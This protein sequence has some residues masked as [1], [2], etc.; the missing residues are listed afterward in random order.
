MGER[1]DDG[2]HG[3]RGLR[4]HARDKGGH[5]VEV[6][7]H[8][9]LPRAQGCVAPPELAVRVDGPNGPARCSA[10]H[11][12]RCGRRHRQHPSLER[13]APAGEHRSLGF[14]ARVPAGQPAR[15]LGDHV[16]M[17]R[18]D[19]T[20][21]QG[22]LRRGQ[23]TGRESRD[24]DPALRR[25]G[26]PTQRRGNLLPD[27]IRDPNGRSSWLVRSRTTYSS[28]TRPAEATATNASPGGHAV[29]RS[30]APARLH[31]R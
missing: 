25:R 4:G 24:I 27:C 13:R 18:A 12:Q 5:A 31:A 1:V 23:G 14:V 11:G 10:S 26:R 9:D 8:V 3:M 6:V 17:A 21:S 15:R 7:P 19:R 30:P 20:I 16:H 28:I 22:G 29:G 2:Q